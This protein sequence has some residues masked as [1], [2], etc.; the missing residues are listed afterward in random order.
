MMWVDALRDAVKQL[1]Q[2]DLVDRSAQQKERSEELAEQRR[3]VEEENSRQR[4]LF[5]RE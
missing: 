1:R 4:K 5:D 2:Q 3:R